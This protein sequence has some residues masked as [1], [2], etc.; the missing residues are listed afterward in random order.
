MHTYTGS[1]IKSLL[2]DK[3]Y[4]QNKIARDLCISKVTVHLVI[5]GKATSR[6]VTA[7]IERL[8]G[9]KPGELKIAR[10]TNRNIA[11]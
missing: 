10:A 1:E 8:L 3:G 6:P 4:N 2:S 5:W 7:H 11:V 9:M